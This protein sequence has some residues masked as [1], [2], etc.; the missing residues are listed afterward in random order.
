LDE[1]SIANIAAIA[2]AERQIKEELLRDRKKAN[3]IVQAFQSRFCKENGLVSPSQNSSNRTTVEIVNSLITDVRVVIAQLNRQ[4]KAENIEELKK[5]NKRL[6]LECDSLREQLKSVTKSQ[7]TSPD[8]DNYVARLFDSLSS[9]NP[10]SE[11]MTKDLPRPTDK[12]VIV[13]QEVKEPISEN[14]NSLI[15]FQILQIAGNSK[16]VKVES[17]IELCKSKLGLPETTIRTEIQ[18]LDDEAMIVI[19]KTEI[20]PTAKGV[21]YPD[22]FRL[23][24][25]GMKLADVKKESELERWINQNKG[26]TYQEVPLIFYAVEEFLP[27]HGYSLV[28]LFEEVPFTFKSG[29]K[30]FTPHI[31]L[32]NDKGANIYLMFEGSGTHGE[33]IHEY[34]DDYYE[35]TNGDMYFLCPNGKI[36]RS[37]E[38]AVNYHKKNSAKITN[39]VDWAAYDQK[40]VAGNQVPSTIWFVQLRENLNGSGRSTN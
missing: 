3:E 40:L 8:D 20:K 9:Q 26:I 18:K 4:I 35:F 1:I 31:H 27:K 15:N 30:G 36:A 33:S 34:F 12:N 37:V 38:G 16:A 32:K 23:T 10:N 39:I 21:I 7:Q 13:K 2:D 29:R 5:E 11:P 24:K 28:N 6:S 19:E 22:I 25:S 14:K 17:L